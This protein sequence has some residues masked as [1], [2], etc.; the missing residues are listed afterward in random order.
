MKRPG[1]ASLPPAKR[2]RQLHSTDDAASHGPVLPDPLDVEFDELWETVSDLNED[3]L[4]TMQEDDAQ[5]WG[6]ETALFR[7]ADAERRAEEARRM[8]EERAHQAAIEEAS[9]MQRLQEEEERQQRLATRQAHEAQRGVERNGNPHSSSPARGWNTNRANHEQRPPP[10]PASSPF[11]GRGGRGFRPI[12]VP[13]GPAMLNGH[14][15]AASSSPA[16]GIPPRN[17]AFGNATP[18]AAPS[19]FSRG[20]LGSSRSSSPYAGPPAG[21]AGRGG[22]PGRFRGAGGPRRGGWRDAR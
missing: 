16:V 15:H 6:S 18:P 14:G 8:E 10:G 3:D 9:R 2:A 20:N 22:P 11:A 17:G 12:G 7:Q 4:E 13:T 19:S 1:Q 21:P 5:W